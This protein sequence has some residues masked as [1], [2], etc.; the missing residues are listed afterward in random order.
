MLGTSWVCSLLAA[1][2]CGWITTSITNDNNNNM[3]IISL[4]LS[5]RVQNAFQNKNKSINFKSTLL[6]KIRAG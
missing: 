5:A 1:G 4:V 6:G 2:S 3:F